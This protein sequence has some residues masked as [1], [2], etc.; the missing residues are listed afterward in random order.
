MKLAPV[1]IIDT[2]EQT[3]LVFTNLA[4]NFGLAPLLH[5]PLAIISDARLS[6]RTDQ[7]IVTERLLSISGEDQ[8]DV[9]LKHRDAWSGRL[10]TR[11]MIL[12]NELPRLSDSSG[13]LAGRFIVL[14]MT[15]SFFGQEDH[16]LEARLMTELP[17]ILNWAI[18]GWRRLR[19]RGRFVQPRS[20]EQAI[21]ELEDLGSPIGAFLKDRCVVESGYAV[22]VDE[23]YE[24][25]RKWCTAVG[26]DNPGS[27]HRS[28]RRRW[29]T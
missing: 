1:I 21:Q 9:D 4:Q 3:P 22:S 12:T 19:E 24:A 25:W 17:G 20:S 7:A 13:A 29:T 27:Q 2:R 14:T 18:D 15:R 5:K 6:G 26:R 11:L 23:L 8:I 10:P 28:R 16:E